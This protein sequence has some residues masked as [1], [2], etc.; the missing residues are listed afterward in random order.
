MNDLK[1]NRSFRVLVGAFCLYI[2]FRLWRDGW[3]SS[4][5]DSDGYG[6][7][8]LVLAVGAMVI[9]FL[10]LVGIAGIAIVSGVLP[11][12]SKIADYVADQVG[13]LRARYAA[14]KDKDDPSFDWRPLLIVLLVYFL[15]SS[16]RLTSLISNIKSIIGID[17]VV[18]NV[19][20]AVIYIDDD[21]TADQLTIAN[22]SLVADEFER[23]KIERRL[24]YAGQGLSGAEAWTSDLIAKAE[25]NGSSLIV[26]QKDGSIIK[27]KLP[28]DVERYKEIAAN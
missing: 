12:L 25:P 18:E 28:T 3:F 27:Y 16:G 23:R 8:E 10:E 14:G 11:E 22:S 6:N 19:N 2:A 13:N 9:N 24:Y 15:V 26:T 20:R 7:A 1:S 4:Y 17:A 5:S 21:A